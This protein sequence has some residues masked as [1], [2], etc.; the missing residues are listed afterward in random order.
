MNNLDYAVSLVNLLRWTR[1]ADDVKLR[2]AI[3]GRFFRL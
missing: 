2:C 3:H 1:E